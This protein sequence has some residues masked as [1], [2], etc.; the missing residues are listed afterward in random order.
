M[1]F[2]RL[3]ALKV[4]LVVSIEFA[5]PVALVAKAVILM[6]PTAHLVMR[7][8]TSITEYVGQAVIRVKLLHLSI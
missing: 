3:A 1:D 4:G 6:Q 5:Q 7:L 2:V 8:N